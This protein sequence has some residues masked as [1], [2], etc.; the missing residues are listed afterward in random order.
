MLRS[1]LSLLTTIAKDFARDLPNVPSLAAPLTRGHAPPPK[2]KKIRVLGIQSI[3]QRSLST[4]PEG[5]VRR[6]HCYIV[7]FIWRRL[8]F[9]EFVSFFSRTRHNPS[10]S[11]SY[12]I[13]R[14]LPSK[15]YTE[16]EYL[17]MRRV[18]E[19]HRWRIILW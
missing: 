6:P 10:N 3:V 2:K 7:L 15:P 18:V 5:I 16:E 13:F 9:V 8:I 1:D 11:Y 19:F 14:N 12:V 17:K 4:F